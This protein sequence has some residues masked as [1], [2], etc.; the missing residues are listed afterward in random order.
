M[1]IQNG[2]SLGVK[3]LRQAF[4]ELDL[5]RTGV[6]HARHLKEALTR[7]GF[8]LTK[9]ELV[10][11]IE[12]LDS[13]GNGLI[14]YTDFLIATMEVKPYLTQDMAMVLFKYFDVDHSGL[15]TS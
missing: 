7:N 9:D 11:I 1:A 2:G 5:S 14:N 13:N 4:G 15:I 10:S 6:L 3:D 12:N 8:I